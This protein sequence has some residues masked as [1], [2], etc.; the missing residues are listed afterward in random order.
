MNMNK[1]FKGKIRF[2]PTKEAMSQV[3]SKDALHTKESTF[4]A[5]MDYVSKKHSKEW[6]N[7]KQKVDDEGIMINGKVDEIAFATFMLKQNKETYEEYE[8]IIKEIK[9]KIEEQQREI[10]ALRLYIDENR[11][12]I[13]QKELH[14]RILSLC[15][16]EK[17]QRELQSA[18]EQELNNF[19][20]VKKA[21]DS[22]L[23]LWNNLEC[24]KGD[25]EIWH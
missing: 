4:A 17:K 2:K 25:D 24:A 18:L 21:F 5:L 3:L 22:T 23:K 16:K 19:E 6:E 11:E 20:E 12:K 7:Y 1:D 9:Q 10:E 14:E 13:T 8:N 15:N